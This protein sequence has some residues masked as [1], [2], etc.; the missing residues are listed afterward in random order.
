MRKFTTF[1]AS[2][3]LFGLGFAQTDYHQVRAGSSALHFIDVSAG[4]QT[5][6]AIDPFGRLWIWGRGHAGVTGHSS[7][8]IGGSDANQSHPVRVG[9]RPDHENDFTNRTFTSVELNNHSGFAIES[10]GTL[11]GW[12]SHWNYQLGLGINNNGATQH[13]TGNVLSEPWPVRIAPVSEPDLKF[14]QISAGGIMANPQSAFVIALDVYG[15]IWGWGTNLNGRLGVGGTATTP[16]L[17]TVEAG[18]PAWNEETNYFTFIDANNNSQAMA[19]DNEGRLWAWGGDMFGML[20]QP[21]VVNTVANVTTNSHPILVGG[22]GF[23]TRFSAVSVSNRNV[24]A[25]E[26]DDDNPANNGRLWSWGGA[27]FGMR[28]GVT[29][30]ETVGQAT[31]TPT[32][33]THANVVNRRFVSIATSGEG[34]NSASAA[35]VSIEGELFTWGN[36]NGGRTL[37]GT[38]NT[39]TSAP[40]IR[41]VDNLGLIERVVKGGGTG[42]NGT[43]IAIRRDGSIITWGTGANGALG[44]GS[45]SGT[46]NGSAA[47]PFAVPGPFLHGYFFTPVGVSIEYSKL[48]WNA[49][50]HAAGYEVRIRR[51]ADETVVGEYIKLTETTLDLSTIDALGG[52]YKIDIR[53]IAPV[54]YDAFFED[55]YSAWSNEVVFAQAGVTYHQ[56]RIDLSALGLTGN[57]ISVVNIWWIDAD[58]DN[59]RVYLVLGSEVQFAGE[60]V[61]VAEGTVLH[62]QITSSGALPNVFVN[63]VVRLLPNNNP[64][65]FNQV[66]NHARLLGDAPN[67]TLQENVVI[68][69][70]PMVNFAFGSPW[71]NTAQTGLVAGSLEHRWVTPQ[72]RTGVFNAAN[73]TSHPLA[74]GAVVTVHWDIEEGFIGSVRTGLATNPVILHTVSEPGPGQW[75]H[76]ALA[77]NLQQFRFV[78]ERNTH[79][80]NVADLSSNEAIVNFTV[81]N[82]DNEVLTGET[83]NAVHNSVL[84]VSWELVPNYEAFLY[85]NGTRFEHTRVVSGSIVRERFI[86]GD[87]FTVTQNVTLEIRT[88]SLFRNVAVNVD[89]DEIDGLTSF[90]VL[91]R[92][93]NGN[94]L[95]GESITINFTSEPNYTVWVF[96]NGSLRTPFASGETIVVN[97]NMVITAVAFIERDT[98]HYDSLLDDVIAAFA[99]VHGWITTTNVPVSSNGIRAV[100]IQ[101]GPN[102]ITSTLFAHVELFDSYESARRY[103]ETR[104]VGVAAHYGR[105]GIS[106]HSRAIIELFDDIFAG[107]VSTAPKTLSLV[108][109]VFASD[110]YTGILMPYAGVTDGVSRGGPAHNRIGTLESYRLYTLIE[111]GTA[112]VIFSIIFFPTQEL[113]LAFEPAGN[114]DFIVRVGNVVFFGRED[115]VNDLR[116]AIIAFVG[117]EPVEYFTVHF[118]AGAGGTKTAEVNGAVIN[119]GGRVVS[120]R[121][122]VFTAVPNDGYQ[123]KRWTLNGEVVTETRSV[124]TSDT[125]TL[126]NLSADAVVTVEFELLLGVG[127]ETINLADAVQIFPN[128]V[129]NELNIAT[130]NNLTIT[131]TAIFNVSGQMI[132]SVA[133]PGHQIDVSSLPQG[134]YFIRIE[135][136]QGTVTKHFVKE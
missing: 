5:T 134:I 123:V 68:E 110:L 52:R 30:N 34:S 37:S 122:V 86:S 111:T 117:E 73:P 2:L 61:E 66:A 75:S 46:M 54:G 31:A 9:I 47:N 25:L 14:R 113:M 17:I 64:I 27:H 1:F 128:P 65:N 79:N 58:N 10:D 124:N 19:I 115:I 84:T 119:S 51:Y 33:A 60:Y 62:A 12:G 18:N 69:I 116:D 130:D 87:E 107:E 22:D 102:V 23:T 32:L 83:N 63:N 114:E 135:T 11:W 76:P 133:N 55:R 77:G 26:R 103:Y 120:G 121:D 131:G 99:G 100:N 101:N 96:I 82:A 112:N 57:N 108:Q 28:P 3:F 81:K 24:L 89:V 136:D 7:L 109:R 70:V 49:V 42:A 125:F 29:P 93:A 95:L 88:F 74:L 4:S 39:N 59:A 71:P 45:T 106:A 21:G 92:D 38:A 85:V 41:N 105:I 15:R 98:N 104:A 118:S 91:G 90:E 6:A 16:R 126:S 129:R 80:V 8:G 20:G 94:V 50:P 72:G 53:A 48:S 132:Q 35:A 56:V 97:S 44:N 13:N 40:A 127:I 67:N 78:V 36:Q 43:P